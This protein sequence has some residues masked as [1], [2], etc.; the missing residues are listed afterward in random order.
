MGIDAVA[1]NERAKALLNLIAAGNESA[2]EQLF[3]AFSGRVFA[4]TRR[5]LNDEA[6][7]DEVMVDTMYEVWK[8]ADRFRGDA[9]VSTW[10]LGIARNKALMALRSAAPSTNAVDI[11]EIEEVMA[12]DAPDGLAELEAKERDALLAHCMER[13]NEKHRECVHLAHYE[14]LPLSEVARLLAIP[15]GTVKSR[16]N[17]A[18]AQLTQ[19]LSIQ[20]ART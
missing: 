7:A 2:F 4:F 8:T 15:E 1:D 19:C 3:E 10:I 9:K 13:L 5:M 18:K 14:E 17:T 6:R 11:S 12:S 16:L 20:L